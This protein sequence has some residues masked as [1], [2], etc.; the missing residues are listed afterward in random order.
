MSGPASEITKSGLRQAHSSMRMQASTPPP[1]APP[2]GAGMSPL[3]NPGSEPRPPQTT[4]PVRRHRRHGRRLR[5]ATPNRRPHRSAH[6]AMAGAAVNQVELHPRLQQDGLSAGERACMEILARPATPRQVAQLRHAAAALRTGRP[7]P[8]VRNTE[9][10]WRAHRRQHGSVRPA[11]LPQ[12]LHRVRPDPTGLS[13]VRPGRQEGQVPSTV[14][15]A[16]RV[17]QGRP[18]CGGRDGGLSWTLR[19]AR[20]LR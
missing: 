8:S 4:R 15:G 16:G 6:Q 1:A 3:R 20:P 13:S 11:L 7:S 5:A 12:R 10:G 18:A 2:N 17:G 14:Q 19:Q 9:S